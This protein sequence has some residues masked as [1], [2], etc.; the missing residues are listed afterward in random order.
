M[1]SANTKNHRKTHTIRVVFSEY[2][3][4]SRGL[5]M[6]R[7]HGFEIESRHWYTDEDG[8]RLFRID[9]YRNAAGEKELNTVYALNLDASYHARRNPERG[10]KRRERRRVLYRLPKVLA[11]IKR[12]AT[13]WL[14][15][16][17]K[18]AEAL[19]TLGIVATTAPYGARHWAPEY[20]A[21]LRGAD[22]VLVA[23]DD[24]PGWQRVEMLKKELDV[25][26]LRIVKAA[27]GK[28]ASD[29]IAAGYGLADF[30]EVA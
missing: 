1:P 20:T 5:G 21:Q 2:D 24:E 6:E 27:E 3:K 15:E 14:C 7:L 30:Q 8:K 22:L 28:D 19:E 29:H 17:E 26:S 4:S 25:A 16:G 10:T 18:D 9:R 23:D 13:V 12:G 11:A